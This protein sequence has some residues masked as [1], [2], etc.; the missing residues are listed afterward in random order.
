MLLKSFLFH[1][2]D[3]KA[4][5]VL[6]ECSWLLSFVTRLKSALEAVS[7]YL[8]LWLSSLPS[9]ENNFLNNEA[10]NMLTEAAEARA[11]ALEM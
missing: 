9:L 1:I 3:L 6:G 2:F 7:S 11:V 4:N 5:S 8:P 10:K